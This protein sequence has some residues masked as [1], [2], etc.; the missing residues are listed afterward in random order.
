MR[1]SYLTKSGSY[2]VWPDNEDTSWQNRCDYLCHVDP[3]WTKIG[4]RI[5]MVFTAEDRNR[6][7]E[8]FNGSNQQYVGWT[9]ALHVGHQ[10]YGFMTKNVGCSSGMIRPC[11][12][13]I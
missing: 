2:Y 13:L 6:C 12:N 11:T 4:S 1:L 9:I 3:Q 5:K 8:K 10:R 7:I